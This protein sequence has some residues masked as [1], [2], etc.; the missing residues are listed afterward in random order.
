M[1]KLY[2]FPFGVFTSTPNDLYIDTHCSMYA[3]VLVHLL[4]SLVLELCRDIFLAGLGEF[5][6]ACDVDFDHL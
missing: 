6:D 5:T 3:H 1:T 2:T 4:G